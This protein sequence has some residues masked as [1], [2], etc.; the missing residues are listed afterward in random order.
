MYECTSSVLTPELISY[1]SGGISN[2]NM[3]TISCTSHLG[4]A[5]LHAQYF[6]KEKI[7][8]ILLDTYRHIYA[9]ELLI[10]L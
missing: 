2:N 7:H 6:L 3:A 10:D 8:K 9:L 4:M 1:Y 5:F